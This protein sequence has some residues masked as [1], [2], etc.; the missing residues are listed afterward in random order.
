MAI[1]GIDVSA[2]QGQIDFNSVKESGIEIVYIRSSAGNSYIDERFEENYKKAQESG[3]SIGFYH[4]VNARTLEEAKEE[5]RFFASVIAGKSTNCRLAMD[6]EVFTG[7]TKAEV[8]KIAKAFLNE[9]ELLTGKEL[10]IYSD[11][12]N[13]REVFD[14]DLF[15]EYPLW[16][17]EYDAKSPSVSSYIGW[18]YTDQGTIPGINNHV[19][20]DIFDNTI[21][22]KNQSNIKNPDIPA[23][24]QTKTIYYRVKSGDNLTKIAKE[25]H[26]SISKIISLNNF[27]NPNLIFPNEVIKIETN[28]TYQITN[29][30]IIETYIVKKKDTLTKI[31]NKYNV[32]ISNLVTWNNIK[33][34]NL[35][36]PGEII[37]IEPR[38]NEHLI[39]YIVKE[40]DTLDKIAREYKTSVYEL[41]AINKISNSNFIK[42]GEIIYIP[43]TYI[44]KKD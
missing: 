20:C 38:T 39:K 9:L 5:A 3:L 16:V 15:N 4:Y 6:F 23:E 40:K 18:Q 19:D 31:A 37:K 41:T 10:V 26:T 35:I 7:L 13:A 43:Q 28:Y 1:A 36:Y 30:G 25:Y 42:A 34:P 8:N 11:A 24:S 27:K 33:N 44:Y 2:W 21:Y 12:Y 17:A 32:L 22:L 14:Y 29:T